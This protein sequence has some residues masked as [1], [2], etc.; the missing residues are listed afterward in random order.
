MSRCTDNQDVGLEAA[1][2]QRVRNSS[3]VECCGADNDRG[4]SLLPKPWMA[5]V[6][7]AVVEER[8]VL[9]RSVIARRRGAD[10]SANAGTSSEKRVKNVFAVSQRF[11]R[12]R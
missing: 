3:L 2:I 12:Q 10:R 11:P 7:W 5:Q 8:S 9:R 4:S 6:H 1:T